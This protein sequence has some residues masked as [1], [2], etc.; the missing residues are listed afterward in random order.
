[1]AH[2]RLIAA[3]V[4]APLVQCGATVEV[5]EGR[6]PPPRPGQSCEGHGPE[7]FAIDSID[8]G[9]NDWQTLG[10]DLDRKLTTKDS[11]DVCSL[12]TG[13]PRS[14]Q[15]DGADGIDDAFGAL[16]VPILEDVLAD[17]QPSSTLT[18]AIRAG[19]FTLQLQIVGL[20]DTPTQTC[21][22]LVGQAFSS[23]AYDA[24]P[25]F[26]ETTDWPVMSESL[27]D[28]TTV[29]AGSKFAFRDAY[30]QAG[31][32]VAGARDDVDVPLHLVLE[33]GNALDLLVHHALLTFDH[34]TAPEAANGILAGVLDPEELLAAVEV[35]FRQ[36]L[37]PC[38]GLDCGDGEGDEIRGMADMLADG[39]NL[40]GAACSSI[41][42]AIGFHA[43]R[44][45]NP[46]SAAPP[47]PPPAPLC[48]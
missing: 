4:L 31:T 47:L 17:P 27:S 11:T 40:P 9:E 33:N 2:P 38:C 43:R 20:D 24:T 29:A 26:D 46:T 18:S 45:A 36:E 44:V 1:M 3:L 14:N 28:P 23:D 12:H 15:A 37:Q 30:V 13:A 25:T 8:L 19:R 32:F 41:S 35:A 7:T 21:D 39:T 42:F 10:Y 16:F 22:G 5:D 34:A 48:P 6:R